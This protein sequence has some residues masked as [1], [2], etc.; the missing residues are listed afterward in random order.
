MPEVE[1]PPDSKGEKNE[2]LGLRLELIR[3]CHYI[4]PFGSKTDSNTGAK[5]FHGGPVVKTSPFNAGG[6]RSIPGRRAKIPHASW[7][8]KIA[9]PKT[10]A[11][12]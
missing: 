12:L 3:S 2:N 10:E 6:A 5:D 7:T 1:N 8:K 11:I 4:L 9:N